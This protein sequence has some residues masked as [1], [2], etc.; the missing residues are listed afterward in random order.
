M[1]RRKLAFGSQDL[2]ETVEFLQDR[3]HLKAPRWLLYLDFPKDLTA[4][5]NEMNFEFQ[6]ETRHY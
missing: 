5:L 4:K 1:N 3:Y 2:S 6:G